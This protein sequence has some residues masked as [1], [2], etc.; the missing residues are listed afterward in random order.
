MLSRNKPNVI[1]GTLLIAF[2]ALVFLGEIFKATLSDF[3]PFFIIAAGLM[4][5]LA[6]VLAGKSTGYLAIPGSIITTIGLILLFQNLTNRWESWSYA[7]ALI[8]LSVGV[9]LWIFGRF[10]DL[11]DLR[12]AGRHVM[13]I[14]LVLFIVFGVFFELLIGISGANRTNN[15]MWPLALVAL[16]VYLIL[17]RLIWKDAGDS[18]SKTHNVNVTVDYKVTEPSASA[19]NE[20]RTFSG[21]TGVNN[22]GVGTM[23]I[24]QGDKDELRIEADPEIRSRIITEVKDGVLVI[25]HDHDFVDWLRLWTKSL[26]PLRF[27]LTVKDIRYIKISGAGTVKAPS[28]KGDSLELINS[29][30]GS[31]VIENLDVSKFKAELSGAGSMDIAGKVDEQSIKLSGAGSF[32][33]ARLES[34]KADVKLSGVGSATVWVTE[35]LNANLSGMGSVEYYGEPQL[36]QKKTGLGSLKSL[37]KK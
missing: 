15:L 12:R 23:L 28:I 9:G 2:G 20:T 33:G 3:W 26:D 10:S 17:S 31:Q 32:N 22:K 25:W 27:F 1:L 7:W 24:T 16:G 35:S 6:M 8:P 37:G 21:L 11:E 4:F 36:T 34:R 14:G 29:G 30:A 5:F 13:N 18:Q 19:P